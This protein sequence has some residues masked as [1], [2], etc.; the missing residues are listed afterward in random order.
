MHA[1]VCVSLGLDCIKRAANLKLKDPRCSFILHLWK[2]RMMLLFIYWSTFSWRAGA[3]SCDSSLSREAQ[4][5]SS[6]MMDPCSA[7]QSAALLVPPGWI[8]SLDIRSSPAATENH[9]SGLSHH[10]VQ[11]LP[12]GQPVATRQ[13]PLQTAASTM[14]AKNMAHSDQVPP[15]PPSDTEGSPLFWW[16]FELLLKKLS[17]GK[18]WKTLLWVSNKQQQRLQCP[19]TQ[20]KWKNTTTLLIEQCPVFLKFTNVCVYVCV[21]S[22]EGWCQRLMTCLWE[23]VF[24]TCAVYKMEERLI[25][26]LLSILYIASD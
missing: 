17:E 14:E 8:R 24:V 21:C 25:I 22:L 4:I 7:C 19:N 23:C 5:S 12:E 11:E 15:P 20:E 9:S 6:S 2:E 3:S 13:P 1:C 18:S 10:H 26:D 16:I